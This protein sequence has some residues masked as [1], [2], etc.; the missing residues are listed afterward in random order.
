[1]LGE[2]GRRSKSLSMPIVEAEAV[3]LR[4]Y[5]LSE[6]DRIVL[7]ATREHGKVRA[8]AKGVKKPKSRL[9]GSLE[10]LTHLRAKFFLREGAELW[11]LRQCETIH[12]YLGMNPTPEQVCCYSYIGEMIAEFLEELN[13]NPLLFRLLLSTLAAGEAR[14]CDEPLVRYFELWLLK[15]AGVLPDYGSCPACGKCVKQTGFYAQMATGQ[16]LC[17]MCSGG[18]GLPVGPKAMEALGCFQKLSPLEFSKRGIPAPALADLGC[19]TRALIDWSLE[20]PTKSYK[21]LLRL[22][23]RN[24]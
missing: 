18:K 7:F 23:R 21:P 1:M 6:A 13:P 22:W 11:Q 9:A 17:R 24:E 16:G 12:S 2:A 4:Q 19:L 10:P 3:V 15:L 5:S 20:K 8:V 14:G